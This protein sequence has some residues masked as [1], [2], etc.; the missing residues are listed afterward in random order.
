M[1]AAFFDGLPGTTYMLISTNPSPKDRR[2]L[3][4]PAVNRPKLQALTMLLLDRQSGATV[5]PRGEAKHSGGLA[6]HIQLR[7]RADGHA[8]GLLP[9]KTTIGSSP[10]CNLRIE[11][12]G[13]QPLHCLII[14]AEDGLRIRNWTEN[15]KLNG[16]PFEESPL[17]AGDCLSLGSVELDVI[18]R[19]AEVS[20]LVTESAVVVSKDAELMRAGRDH[21]R[22]RSRRLLVALRHERTAHDELR[23][24]I[25][26]LRQRDVQNKA[27]VEAYELLSK[28]HDHLHAEAD[29]LRERLQQ[30]TE[31]RA[32][33]EGAWQELSAESV[34]LDESR[35]SMADENATL[36]ARLDE[37]QQLLERA[38]Q[39]RS[40]FANSAAEVELERAAKLRAEADV[41][42]A[43]ADGKRQ[44]EEQEHRFA[45]QA[46]QFSESIRLLEQE[47]AA[48][49]EIRYSLARAR[50][51]AQAQLVDAES[52][53]LDHLA[54]I[55]DLES[56][57]AEAEERAAKATELAA[58]QSSAKSKDA[59]G[60]PARHTFGDVDSTAHVAIETPAAF[61][62]SSACNELG[63]QDQLHAHEGEEATSSPHLSEP[64][65]VEAAWDRPA[66]AA[67][68]WNSPGAEDPLSSPVADDWEEPALAEEPTAAAWPRAS[69]F[70]A[71]AIAPN[72]WDQQPSQRAPADDSLFGEE[73]SS[74]TQHEASNLN[75]TAEDSDVASDEP[76]FAKPQVSD[77][78]E[79]EAEHKP[80]V[81]PERT[82][83][84][85]QYSHLFAEDDAASEEKPIRSNEPAPANVLAKGVVRAEVAGLPTPASEDEDTIEQY[86]AKLLQRVRGDSA[87]AKSTSEQP[88]HMPL[89]APAMQPVDSSTEHSAAMALGSP[90]TYSGG[91]ASA[92][93]VP[94]AVYSELVKR[95]VASLGP[96][97]NFGALRA[98]ANESARMAIS[99][100]E[101]T[102]LRRNAVTKTIVATLAGVTSLWLMLESP[103]WRN[104]QFITACGALLVAAYW[105]GETCRTLLNSLRIAAYEGPEETALPIDVE[106]NL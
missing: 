61:D 74:T 19:R 62:W 25:A 20:Q 96:T 14:E 91:D 56:R 32:A 83:F 55:Q 76:V 100:H 99:R 105:A 35:Q 30:L 90:E 53:R 103:D 64:A 93:D 10:R 37:A 94:G 44:L 68:G 87:G 67:D 23:Q 28:E 5:K 106:E 75:R 21:A 89:N 41:A 86:M 12:P 65:T 1:Q 18:D 66:S 50:E 97:T 24:Q 48:T 98:L 46:R 13:V 78:R 102:K 16:I 2:A 39:E 72:P 54:R 34:T 42:A 70:G 85:E 82:S 31:E 92:S 88:S 47:L 3:C 60:E 9:G 101:L 17:V 43:I 52:R 77:H 95:R 104:I 4:A 63:S 6:C 71:A 11:R 33:V 40:S 79:S 81:K 51:E 45:E 38:Q 84:I 15:T 7:L 59:A 27:V 80:A 8:L 22:I 49:G 36:L 57:L 29:Q 73:E 26:G 58:I 69:E